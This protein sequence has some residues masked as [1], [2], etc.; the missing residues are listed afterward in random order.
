MA[1]G[2]GP[3]ERGFD[4]F[5][6]LLVS[7][8]NHMS[9]NVLFFQDNVDLH[10]WT[11]AEKR[12]YP[13]V[14]AE[15]DVHSTT[16][17][18]REAINFLNIHMESH[19]ELPFFLEVSYTAPHDP[20]Q[21]D[22]LHAAHPA[23]KLLANARR[24]EYCGMIMGVDEGI[25]NITNALENHGILD[26]V[27]F[28]FVS[29]N[30]GEPMVGG[31][32]YPFR[33]GKA[34]IYEGGVRVPGF[35]RYPKEFTSTVYDG[36]FHITDWGPTF[37]SLADRASG[38]PMSHNLGKLDGIDMVQALRGGVMPR[39]SLLVH[40]DQ[41][42]N[43]SG[44][45]SRG[46]DWK[47]LIGATG[48]DKVVEEPTGVLMYPKSDVFL[49]IDQ[50]N[51][52]FLEAISPNFSAFQWGIHFLMIRIRDMFDLTFKSGLFINWEGFRLVQSTPLGN[53]VPLELP[54]LE[55][56]SSLEKIYLFNL[57]E[58][59]SESHNLAYEP[60]FRALVQELHDELLEILSDS[61]GQHL[62]IVRFFQRFIVGYVFFMSLMSICLSFV[63]YRI[64]KWLMLRIPGF[65]TSSKLKIA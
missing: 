14:D 53:T 37:L 27:V 61:P 25:R 41:I 1:D 65:R 43:M 57:K 44:I 60:E 11:R 58:D 36:L 5:F 38:T 4:K 16:M 46:G 55:W 40:S 59:P 51:S 45:I 9:K 32:N 3:L 23:C 15:P 62:V 24:A 52:F 30:G 29:D 22:P 64:V 63:F 56:D 33:G 19:S 42:Q 7:G 8:H 18:T 28:A 50:V 54:S 17:F 6:G 31:Y 47:L 20:V 48:S 13:H 21:S 35:I 10:N 39:Q 49:V 26:D 12:S 34:T 2:A